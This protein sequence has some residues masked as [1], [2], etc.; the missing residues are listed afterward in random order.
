MLV[1]V[2]TPGLIE[3]SA[4]GAGSSAA[5]DGVLIVL[6]CVSVAA[7]WVR[8]LISG[9]VSFLNQGWGRREARGT[10]EAG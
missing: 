3:V 1:A 9:R 4:G 7:N 8:R 2:E 10:R 6:A 5:C